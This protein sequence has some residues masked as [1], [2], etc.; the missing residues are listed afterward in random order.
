M[1]FIYFL[2]G[3]GFI[4]L[5][6]TTIGLNRLD[7]QHLHWKWLSA[8]GLVHGVNEWLELLSFSL[9]DS[10]AF[11][12]V[13]LMVLALSF[14]ALI[15]F[16]RTGTMT[17]RGR[18][19]GRWIYFPLILLAGVGSVSGLSGLN[20][21]IRYSLGFTGSLWSAWVFSRLRRKSY[22][23]NSSLVVA[24]I[25]MGFYGVASGLVVPWAPFFPA[26][27]INQELFR[28]VAG[29][30]IQLLRGILACIVAAAC[31]KFYVTRWQAVVKT[32]LSTPVI[33]TERWMVSVIG[34]VLITGWFVTNIFGEFGK[35]Q[36]VDQYESDLKLL[37]RTFKGYVETADGLVQTLVG[38]QSL[39]TMWLETEPDLAAID[40]TLDRYARIIPD[41]ICYVMNSSGTT[42]ASS[43]RDTPTSFVGQFYG[44]RPY[45]KQAMAG[46]QGRLVA[47]GLTTSEPGYFTSYP[48]RD[49]RGNVVG[50]A[51]VKVTLN[52]MFSLP[53]S[54]KQGFLV[55]A[56][57]IVLSAKNHEYELC[58]IR[59]IDDAVRIGLLASERYPSIGDAAV[60]PAAAVSEF[61][62]TFQGKVMQCFEST[63]SVEGL[64]FVVLGAMD[65]WKTTR[66]VGILITLLSAVLLIAFFVSNQKSRESSESVIA[67]ERLYR[68][69]VE[70]SPNWIGLFD[71]EGVCITVNQNGLSS[72]GRQETDVVGK[73]IGQIWSKTTAPELEGVIHRVLNGE[74]VECEAEQ[75]RKEGSLLTW[76]VVLNPIRESDGSVLSFIGI[77][78]D[79]T[80][81]KASENAL[82]NSEELLSTLISTMPDMLVRMDLN[83]NI[84][85]ANDVAFQMSG[86]D[87]G[88]VEG[89]NM[90][91]FIDPGDHDRMTENTLRMFHQQLGSVEYNLITKSG[92]KL[93]IEV[94]AR[95]LWDKSGCPQGILA[96]CRDYTDHRRVEDA[97][98]ES[99]EKF[100]LT[101]SA[102]PDAV[103]INRL[104]DGLYMD[105]NEGFSRATG[106]SREDVIGKTSLEINIWNNPADREKLVQGLMT[107]GY[108]ENLESQFRRKDGSLITGLMSARMLSLSGVPHIIS[109]TRDITDRK[110]AEIEL[111]ENRQRLAD[112]IEFLPDAT[113]AIDKEKRIIIWNREIEKMTGVPAEDMIGKGDYAYTIPFYGEARSQLMDL[114]FLE[115]GEITSRYQH[116][117]REGGSLVA[118]AFCHALYNNRGAWVLLKASPLHDQSGN[119]IGAIES[120]R[121]ITDRKRA[122]DEKAKLEHQLL[123]AQKFEA[124]GTLAGGVAHDFNNILMGI[125]GRASLLALEVEASQP[126][127]EHV[128]AIEEYVRSA[129]QLT[130]QLLGF[131]GGGKYEAKPFD[132]NELVVGTATMF[133]RT[134]KEIRIHTHCRSSDLVVEADRGQIEQVLLNLYVNAW[135]AMPSSGGDLYLET[136][137]VE[138]DASYCASHQIGPG[139][140]IKISVTD[141]G[142][143]MD[144]STRQQ[145]FDPFFTT[146]DKGRGTGLGLA[147]A[148]GII[149]NHGGVITVYS[150]KGLGTTFNIYLPRSVKQPLPESPLQQ[151]II[152]GSETI[153]LVDDEELIIDVGQAI[154]E[155]LGY[156]VIIAQSAQDAIQRIVEQGKQIDLV[157]LDMIMPGMDGGI[158]FDRIRE[159]EPGIPVILSSGYTVNGDAEKILQRGCN[160]FIQKP[161]NI[162]ELSQKIRQIIR[163]TK[164]EIS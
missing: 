71:H 133:G 91:A 42:I 73:H 54:E 98:R 36:D 143:G 117:I 47:V 48:I 37:E 44:M 97:L 49:N 88:E 29:V 105:I 101:Y 89:R 69:L 41:S 99:E 129:S 114:I 53:I 79:I 108:Y 9:K 66:L 78:N 160:G 25:A 116:L 162:A 33:R 26:E 38:S 163:E 57:G 110:R 144:E 158:C 20:A 111:L 24:A 7:N 52:K 17:L 141:T 62:F 31:W 146:K 43:N 8:F 12:A 124:I 63:T 119:V 150:E 112:I 95:I 130:R 136:T 30:P 148:Y 151:E 103:N 21:A 64:T 19:Q 94:N 22:S 58:P 85:F 127:R 154:L 16:A 138:P 92:N 34:L 102:S 65:S 142:S 75:F 159:I 109:I 155:N 93:P 40:S 56:D 90:L 126:Q 68:S 11:T 161:Y 123:Q 60:L 3:L 96:V 115:D 51:V 84:L 39:S 45:F 157:I 82:R 107:Q 139:P 32:P 27:V 67:S 145:V 100:R 83:G 55:D 122:E 2:Y 86:Y 23:A 104:S 10:P 135:Q 137:A 81:R 15:E 113:L 80:E 59:P 61:L 156:Q 152:K 35:Q 128:R 131:A 28:D 74:Q 72:M 14:L 6:A 149:K 106:F 125:Q 76:R 50:A 147:S 87:W 4:F 13:R 1:D 46:R 134:K 164:N 5:A 120:I 140:Y 18:G 118:E 153:L 121:D 70:G 77:A 132:I